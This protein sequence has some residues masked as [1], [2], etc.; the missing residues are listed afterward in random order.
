MAR[1]PR[2]HFPGACYH[3]ILRGNGGQDIFLDE[4]DR[5]RFL[6]LIQEGVE[7]YRHRIHAFCLMGNHVHLAVQVADIPLSRI[8]QNIGFRYT[9]Y[10]NAKVKRTGHLFQGRYK[11]ILIDAESYLL[12]LI[13]YVHLNPVRAGIV[14]SPDEYRWSSHR[15]YLGKEEV[16]CLTTDW[17]LAQFSNKR[18]DAQRIYKKFIDLAQTEKHRKEFHSGTFE[19]RILGNDDFIERSLAK[20]EEKFSRKF[21]I[22][23]L[24]M[25]VCGYY[26]LKQDELASRGRQRRLSHPRSVL[27]YLVRETEDLKLV[28]LGRKLGRSLTG[29][30]Q[31]A[32]RLSRRLQTNVN[33]FKEVTRIRESTK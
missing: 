22:D 12:E 21:S 3:V 17:L 27:A 10:F 14:K 11:A 15:A 20:A 9:R 6:L 16:T 26:G 7:R 4:K 24:I 32:E 23:D 2:I 8:M 13:R 31:A 25:A 1:K 29:L 33:L 19:G 30:S 18:P 5:H 28:D